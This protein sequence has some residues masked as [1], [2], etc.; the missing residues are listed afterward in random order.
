[1]LDLLELVKFESR[2]GVLMGFIGFLLIVESSVMREIYITYTLIAA[3]YRFF[4]YTNVT[5]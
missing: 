2:V 5:S 4:S 1:M 3:D